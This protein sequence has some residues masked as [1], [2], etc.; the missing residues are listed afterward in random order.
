MK[1]GGIL[2]SIFGSERGR[3]IERNA[4]LKGSFTEVVSTKD[5]NPNPLDTCVLTTNQRVLNYFCLAQRGNKVSTTQQRLKC[6]ELVSLD[7]LP[8]AEFSSNP[9]VRKFLRNSEKLP[10]SRASAEVWQ[11]FLTLLKSLRPSIAGRI[12]E[13]ES[14]R[15]QKAIATNGEGFQTMA[16]EKDAAGLALSIFGLDRS[17][18]LPRNVHSEPAPFL[19]GLER[20]ILRE[21]T[22]IAHDAIT[23]PGWD[24][25]ESHQVGTVQ[26]SRNNQHLTI[27]NVN[28][29]PIEQT[30]GVDLLY[31]HHVYNAYI[32]VQYK[33]MTQEPNLSW[34]FR[35]NE[36][37]CMEELARMRDFNRN[38]PEDTS[39]TT[40]RNYRLN[41]EAFYFKLCES[42]T[43]SGTSSQL[44]SGM[45]IPLDYWENLLE[46]PKVM[47]KRGG[48]RMDSN[49]IERHLNNTDFVSLVQRGWIGSRQNKTTEIT[50]IVNQ[51]L[52]DNH[53]VTI[54]KS[55]QEYDGG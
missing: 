42:V 39:D 14:R 28:R 47:G 43:Y 34:T 18:V 16:L 6:I 17:K 2:I 29:H 32:L 30:L 24:I 51:L 53:S 1:Y 52:N 9:N 49:N 37:Q 27:M 11:E 20:T 4:E 31:Y 38:N 44:I 12:D 35:P 55:S 41:P 19:R 5:I 54:A 48:L 40:V 7:R 50:T 33:R 25:A 21:D 26:F 36:K 15:N 46:S 23:F 8:I 13:L 22:M 10:S 3:Q 45:Y